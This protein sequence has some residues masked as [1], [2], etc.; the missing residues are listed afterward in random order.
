MVKCLK[1][2]KAHAEEDLDKRTVRY[3]GDGWY[4]IDEIEDVCPSCGS[5]DVYP[6][7]ECA[8]CGEVYFLD[9]DAD[10]V[11]IYSMGRKCI[12]ERC[13]KKVS[14]ADAVSVGKRDTKHL[15]VVNGFLASAFTAAEIEDILIDA[16]KENPT[17]AIEEYVTGDPDW[18]AW[19]LGAV[20]KERQ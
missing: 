11:S 18:F 5:S 13:I 3:G 16:L 8:E 2:G 1:C 10:D 7:S 14:L 9:N 17:E 4:G 6:A 15:V 19:Q 20:R 12:C